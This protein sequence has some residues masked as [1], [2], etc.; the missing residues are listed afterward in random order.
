[1]GE[2]ES[3]KKQ[4]QQQIIPLTMKTKKMERLEVRSWNKLSNVWRNNEIL[5]LIILFNCCFD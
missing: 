1:M 5:K 4:Q 2:K 3:V